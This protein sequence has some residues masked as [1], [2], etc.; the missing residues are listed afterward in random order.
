M[1]FFPHKSRFKPTEKW[2]VSNPPRHG[3]LASP[4]GRLGHGRH[5]VWLGQRFLGDDEETK[6]KR[7]KGGETLKEKG[8]NREGHVY[9]YIS[10]L[11]MEGRCFF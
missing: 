9:I 1:F 11:K 7:T 10:P 5:H 6:R 3:F 2:M 4:G 8:K